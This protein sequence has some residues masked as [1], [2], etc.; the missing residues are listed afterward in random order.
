MGS[1][2]EHPHQLNWLILSYI[3]VLDILATYTG[4]S[5]SQLQRYIDDIFGLFYGT[6]PELM[7]W[8]N[9]LNNSH[10]NIKFT[11]DSS[12]L[13]IPFLDSL[14]YIKDNKIHTKLYKKTTDK[15]QYLEYNGNHPDHIKNAIPYAHALRYKRI[16]SDPD[17]LTIELTKLR[18]NFINRANPPL[19]IDTAIDRVNQIDRFD[20]LKCKDLNTWSATPCLLTYCQ[21]LVTPNPNNNIHMCIQRACEDLQLMVSTLS[22]IPPPKIV[23][24]NDI[25]IGNLLVSTNIPNNLCPPNETI[26][27]INI[28]IP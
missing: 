25:N 8:F 4:R 11:K 27:H 22:N 7:N 24:K 2:W 10:P 16:I 15:K 20:L 26:L 13:Q 12:F 21:A 1:L 3:H 18:N 23:F 28:L 14:V 19:I 9:H 17:I 5:P 6:E